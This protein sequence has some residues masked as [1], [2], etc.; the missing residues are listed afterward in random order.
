MRLGLP[1]EVRLSEQG[2]QESI[3]SLPPHWG[4]KCMPPPLCL[5][6]FLKWVLGLNPRTSRLLGKHLY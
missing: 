6:F 5:A 1:M 2:E 4:Y 3:P